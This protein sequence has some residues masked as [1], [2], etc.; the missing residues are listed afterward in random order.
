[1][2]S[3]EQTLYTNLENISLSYVDL[4]NILGIDVPEEIS[5]AEEP[6]PFNVVIRTEEQ[7]RSIGLTTI[8]KYNSANYNRVSINGSSLSTIAESGSLALYN[9]SSL[10]ISFDAISEGD[11]VEFMLSVAYD[12]TL[13]DIMLTL[14]YDT[15]YVSATV[16]NPENTSDI[17]TWFLFF[18][19]KT[20]LHY[21]TVNISEP[22]YSDYV[23]VNTYTVTELNEIITENYQKDPPDMRGV[24]IFGKT[25]MLYVDP[26]CI[27]S[28]SISVTIDSATTTI[29]TYKPPKINM[30]GMQY[31]RA[32]QMNSLNMSYGLLRANPKL[33]GNI[34]VVI[35]SSSNIYLDTFKVSETLQ[36]K[37]YRR[38][39]VGYNDYYGEDI[40]AKFRSVPSTDLYKVNSDCFNM[41]TTVQTYSSQYYDVYNYGVKTNND[42]LYSENF[43]FLAP[44]CIRQEVP[45]FFLIFKIHKES[46]DEREMSDTE[47]IEYFLRNG[48]LVKSYDMRLGSELGTYIRTIRDRASEKIG[49][50]YVSYD[51]KNYTR[52]NG[53]SVDRGI[54][55]SLYE[56]PVQQ[57]YVNNQ[58]ALNDFY[59][60]GFE[61]NRL[62]QK[63]IVNFEFMFN[64]TDEQLFSINTYFGLYVK[65]NEQDESFSCIGKQYNAERDTYEYQFDKEVYTFPIGTDLDSNEIYS[66]LIYG[67]TTP[68]EFIR[69]KGSIYDNSVLDKYMMVPYK[70]ELT[71]KVNEIDD[72]TYNSFVYFK[73]N[74]ILIPGDHIRFID[75]DNNVIY[76]I[77]ASNE[78]SLI[79]YDSDGL[80]EITSIY[81]NDIGNNPM[82]IIRQS[83]YSY[84]GIT[85]EKI[86]QIIK[87]ACQNFNTYVNETIFGVV[88][89]TEDTLSIMS[90][91]NNMTF[92]FL[93][94]ISLMDTD[95]TSLEEYTER[96]QNFFMFNSFYPSKC[97][98]NVLDNWGSSNHM[99]F[100]PI[101][102]EFVGSR[103]AYLSKFVRIHLEDKQYYL[104]DANIDL[105]V[106][107]SNTLMYSQ[108][109][110]SD[111]LVLYEP[112]QYSWF[113]IENNVNF[114]ENKIDAYSLP[115]F[116]ARD[117]QLILLNKPDIVNS[118]VSFYTIIPLN[119]G[120]CSIMQIKDF[121]FDVLDNESILSRTSNIGTNIG[122]P[123]EFYSSSF[124]GNPIF[125]KTE[126]YIQNYF[127][128][129][130]QVTDASVINDVTRFNNLTNQLIQNNVQKSSISLI[131]PYVCKWKSTGTDAR[132][133]GLRIMAENSTLNDSDSFYIPYD[134]YTDNLGYIYNRNISSY[135]EKYIPKSLNHTTY[136]SEDTDTLIGISEKDAILYGDARIDDILYDSKTKENKFS[137]T[138]KTGLNCIEFISGGIKFRLKS[139]N[140][141]ALNLE[142]CI[143]YEATFV[144]IPSSDNNTYPLELIIDKVNRQM[145]LT[146]YDFYKSEVSEYNYNVV[147]LDTPN[148]FSNIYTSENE[149][150]G[151]L[152][153]EKNLGTLNSSDSALF[154]NSMNDD[155]NS[156]TKMRKVIITG[157]LETD[158]DTGYISQAY[159]Y[160]DDS[161]YTLS[162]ESYKQN[163]TGNIEPANYYIL[164]TEDISTIEHGSQNLEKL[165]SSLSDCVI[166]V[167]TVYG[168]D[169]LTNLENILTINVVDPI[170]S[171]RNQN[172]VKYVHPTHIVPVM[173]DMLSFDYTP[174][175]DEVFES[176]DDDMNSEILEDIFKYSFDGANIILNNVNNI[177]QLWYNKYTQNTNFC[178]SNVDNYRL[179]LDLVHNRS[180]MK[181]SWDSNLFYN[182]NALENGQES[183]EAIDGYVGGY[184]IKSF[185][186]SKGINLN[187]SDG[188]QIVLTN[189][190][191]TE[192]SYVD[193]YIKLNIS[194][195][196]MNDIL[197][198]NSF[199]SAWNYLRLTNN[200]Y[201][202]QY[203]NNVILPLIHINNKVKFTFYINEQQLNNFQFSSAFN[204]NIPTISNIK[205]SLKYENNKY[206]MYIY[207][208][209]NGIYY[210]KMTIN[211]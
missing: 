43:A 66:K 211:L 15:V 189:W 156:Y 184:E 103:I 90:S 72:T 177:S 116:I 96:D 124:F 65:V 85:V 128:K 28:F 91:C 9:I 175:V 4:L 47:L 174:V 157:A 49:D 138:V 182:Y 104:T 155:S 74:D 12:N 53:I 77:I 75:E 120:I 59:T 202:I 32:Y 38:I 89:K 101:D 93:C 181:S 148:S 146:M 205:N 48:T 144:N 127:D 61:R 170:V 106:L 79:S 111:D 39:K 63:D 112:I 17:H 187:G 129:Y 56:S 2:P 197:F 151:T 114:K 204:E 206:Y 92:E 122:N 60:L 168:V 139:N 41:F 199:N 98:L 200:N 97:I 26:V 164:S 162:S 153:A 152:Y 141:N 194:D 173:K 5:G 165:K 140:S 172:T 67:L 19:N 136:V 167:K 196:L 23:Y 108:K 125:N 11:R 25:A 22:R 6:T 87:K 36:Q 14:S 80:S 18:D 110:D 142:D 8:R 44:L 143:G 118:Q 145:L 35:D 135:P 166:Y 88:E 161:S 208:E 115:C 201:K 33:T 163:A 46:I 159:V 34:K 83:F 24:P 68:D 3:L 193:Q 109:G 94:S 10:D 121:D 37:R 107:A 78:D 100:Y 134:N 1:M 82:T 7:V 16:V 31:K 186:G 191:N 86:V 195:T 131:A 147:K 132:G 58:V 149:G 51:T 27:N 76:E 69:L 130:T 30:S 102:F 42:L 192:I 169:D 123:G 137:L 183:K 54:V 203:I 158:N 113:S 179:S 171:D 105:S 64:D 133:E 180:I 150:E 73:I 20:D 84:S 207:P 62:V 154:V 45:D 117:A 52:F 198:R 55:T 188:K 50:V 160:A 95:L 209:T 81:K 210:A 70:N 119:S 29:Y 99:L 190:Q 21:I 71:L 185:F 178:I 176:S 13:Y 126:E 40:M 57:N